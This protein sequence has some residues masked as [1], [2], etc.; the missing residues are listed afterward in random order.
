MY[1]TMAELERSGASFEAHR[2]PTTV[3]AGVIASL[4]TGLSPRAHGLEDQGAR[5]P[6]AL[7]TLGVAA[8]DGS[9][10]TAMFTGCPPTFEAFG[11]ARGWDKYLAYSPVEGAPAVA[12][13]TDSIRWTIDHMKAPD[14]RALVVVHARGGHPPW[15][16]TMNEAA[17]LPP[18]EY[19]GPIDPRRGGQVIGRARARHS[20]FRLTESDR[21]RMWSIYDA[22]LGGQDRALGQFL[23]ALKK[24]SLWDEALFIVTGDVSTS[25]DNR[26]PFGDGE[27]LAEPLLH[28]PLWVHFPTSALAG[29]RV[30]APTAVTDL[31]RTILDALR[32]PTPDGF[33]GIDLFTTAAGAGL[34]AGRPLAATLGSRYSV[35]LGDLVLSGTSGKPPSLCD[36][37]LD[38]S[39]E[40]DRLDRM[41]RAGSLLFR[42]MYDAEVAAQK[43]KLAREPATVDASTAA[44]MLVWGE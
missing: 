9:I 33:E 29:G 40:V 42:F 8:R 38:P 37:S 17:K 41:P 7:T 6:G 21:T 14:A 35:R 32:L 3:S 34:A 30:D 1:P 23:D 27:D 12:P 22:A 2:V 4:L 39:C 28:V 19:S 10:Q 18:P 5:L 31:S 15:D 36:L 13:L 24:A 11:F 16:V 25:S 44:A 20:R 43:Q 26:A